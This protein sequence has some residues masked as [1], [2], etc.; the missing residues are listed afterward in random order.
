MLFRS[1]VEGLAGCLPEYLEEH[2]M[3]YFR[4]LEDLR[5]EHD[6]ELRDEVYYFE[7]EEWKGV[8]E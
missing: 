8:R 5:E 6:A 4:E 3:I 2:L 7:N 1:K